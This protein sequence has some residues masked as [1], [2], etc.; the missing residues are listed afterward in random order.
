MQAMLI[1]KDKEELVIQLY[2]EGKP[3]RDI[4][5]QAHLSFGNYWLRIQSVYVPAKF[6]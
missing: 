5:H 4:A 1:K 6:V 2:Q 3:M